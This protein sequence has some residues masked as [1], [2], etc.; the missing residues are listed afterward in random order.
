MDV[1]GVTGKKYHGKDT[2]ARELVCHGF[3]VVRFAGPLK[4][5]IRAFYVEHGLDD[6]TIDRKLEG[7]LKET[8]CSFLAGKT[9][10]YAMQTLGDEWGRQLIG[11][12]LWIDSF[13]A[14]AALHEKVVVP[15][16]RYPNEAEAIHRLGGKVWRIDASERVA[17]NEFSS[18][19]SETE[20]DSLIVDREISNNGDLREL[21]AAVNAALAVSA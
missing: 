19:A 15:D 14:R 13:S 18:H 6:V 11:R 21:S 20:V 16:T 1:I 17:P 8:P 4:A 7:D 12:D 5:M 2:V 9:P 3:A 10:R